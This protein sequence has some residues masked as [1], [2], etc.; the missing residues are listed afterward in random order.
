MMASEVQTPEDCGLVRDRFEPRTPL[1]PGLCVGFR[2]PLLHVWRCDSPVLIYSTTSQGAV[3][4]TERLDRCYT[5]AVYDVM[6][7][8]D[9]SDCVLPREIRGLNPGFSVS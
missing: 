8:R 5:G 6:R 7:E 2:G 3:A 9:R 1:S 4:L